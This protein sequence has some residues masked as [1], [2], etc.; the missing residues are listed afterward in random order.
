MINNHHLEIMRIYNDINNRQKSLLE[1]RKQEIA[2]KLPEINNIDRQIGKLCLSV[3]LNT[4]QSANK[5]QDYLKDLKEK[6]T[7][8]RIKKSELLVSNGYPLDYLQPQ[9]DCEKCKDTG[10]IGS[11]KCSC[12]KSKLVKIYYENSSLSS[13][14]EKNNFENFN[15]EYYSDKMGPEKYTPRYNIQ[16]IVSSSLNFIKTFDASDEN[17]LFYGNSGTGKT[18][19][20]HCIAKDLIDR[21][22]FIIYKTAEELVKSIRDIRFNG[23]SILEEYINNCDLLIIDDL[24]TEMSSDFSKTELF[25]LLNLRLLTNKKMIV[26]TNYSLEELTNIY[27]ERITSRLIG[28]FTLCKFYGDDIRLQKKFTKKH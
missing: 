1:S 8:L 25:N 4:L 26:S 22:Y 16:R 28:N 7:N 13:M 18:F 14:L 20:S 27:S 2:M 9:Y 15:L 19:L 10:F 23:N 3:S 21:G 24:G 5:G 6:I 11:E 17:L 12:Y